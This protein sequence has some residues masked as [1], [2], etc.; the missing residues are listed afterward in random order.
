MSL[1]Y[2]RHR[3]SVNKENK[4]SGIFYEVELV[5]M[6]ITSKQYETL[7]NINYWLKCIYWMTN[8]QLELFLRYNLEY[9][10]GR[11]KIIRKTINDIRWNCLRKLIWNTK[12]FI[13]LFHIL[14]SSMEYVKAIYF[15]FIPIP[16]VYCISSPRIS[17]I[18]KT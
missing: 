17:H 12:Q 9:K 14:C 5:F 1:V 10:W 6:V 11:Y 3:L 7:V 13:S 18:T 16:R 8:K 4:C 15:S 2:D